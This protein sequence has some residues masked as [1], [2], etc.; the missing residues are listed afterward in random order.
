MLLSCGPI[1]NSRSL[2]L[3]CWEYSELMSVLWDLIYYNVIARGS[4]G[5]GCRNKPMNQIKQRIWLLTVLFAVYWVQPFVMFYCIIPACLCGALLT[6]ISSCPT[7]SI[8]DHHSHSLC[9]N[10]T[11]S[12]R[13]FLLNYTPFFIWMLYWIL[14]PFLTICPLLNTHWAL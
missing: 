4:D 3:Y 7:E 9:L 2:F 6:F 10:Y 14:P 13:G 8:T 1:S 5:W 11:W 12:E